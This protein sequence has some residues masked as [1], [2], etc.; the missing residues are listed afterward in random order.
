MKYFLLWRRLEVN[1]MFTKLAL[2]NVKRQV[3][4]YLIYF[5]TVTLTVALMFAIHNVIFSE[6]LLAFST[7]FKEM[8]SALIMLSS[9]IAIVCAFVLGYATSFM[10]RLRKR[11]FG[12]YL[13]LGMTRKNILIVFIV[14]T[15]IMGIAALILGIVLGL[16]LYQGLMLV[17]TN[18]MD[19]EFAFATYSLKGLILTVVL[20]VCIFILA[21]VTSAMYLRK[22]SVYE[23]IHGDKKSEKNVKHPFLWLCLAVISLASIITFIILFSN[24][25]T[26][27]MNTGRANGGAMFS[28]LFAIALTMIVF[29]TGLAKCLVSLMLKNKKLCSHGTNTFVLRQLSGRL[30]ANALMAGALSFLIAFAIIGA[31][32]SFTQKISEE[33]NLNRLIPFDVVGSFD[34]EDDEQEVISIEK[35]KNIIEG[36]VPIK[37]V[38]PYCTYTDGD[39][40]LTQKYTQY[41]GQ[42]YS[43]ITDIFMKQSEFNKYAKSLGKPTVTGEDKFYIMI[44]TPFESDFA[45]ATLTRNGQTCSFGGMLEN[46]PRISLGYFIVIV[47]DSLTEGMKI[48]NQLYGIDLEN[49]DFDAEAMMADLTYTTEIHDEEMGN[50][51][52]SRTD[53]MVKEYNRI[54]NNSTSAI[55]VIG[56]IY[57]AVVFVFL[58]MAI[59]ALKTLAG[60]SEDRQKYSIL[61]RLGAGENEQ[62]KALFAQTLS[63]FSLPFIVPLLMSIP[64]AIICANIMKFG[65]L[66]DIIANVYINAI[67]I[68]IAM[69]LIYILYFTATYLILRKNIIYRN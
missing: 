38:L 51:K 21:S 50:F 16:F 56:A 33:T 18:L 26:T 64:S 29:H 66:P 1:A 30:S 52:V 46:Y 12:T 13:T 44:N 8:N 25:I 23:L 60:I 15:M 24:E 41:T 62:R 65:G 53:F 68:A 7:S 5:I 4:N 47:P 59:L 20:V 6:Q 19:M 48:E 22:V 63:F 45:N 39:G 57:V 42:N 14:E 40:E 54:Q 28:Y 31:N 17:M 36:Y 9:L 37:N 3:G 49:N 35:A 10:L 69:I 34:L 43:D 2:R 61:Y 27:A 58:A 55:L 32:V 67:F 11:E